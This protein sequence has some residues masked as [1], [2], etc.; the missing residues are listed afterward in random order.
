MGILAAFRRPGIF[1]LLPLLL[2]L[3][4][5]LPLNL[6]PVVVLA[7]VQQPESLTLKS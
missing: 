6:L 1:L 5:P 7:N 2:A 3:P 4:L